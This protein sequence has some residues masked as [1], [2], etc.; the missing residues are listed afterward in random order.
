MDRTLPLPALLLALLLWPAS[1]FAAPANES[2][3]CPS[4]APTDPLQRANLLSYLCYLAIPQGDANW[5]AEYPELLSSA[6]N[7]H[8]AA[9][10]ELAFT[11]TDATYW[12]R[13]NVHNPSDRAGFWYLKLNYAPLDYVTLMIDSGEG[14]QRIETGDQ[15]PFDS[16]GIDYR[17]YLLPIALEEGEAKRI[18]IKLRSSGALN[19]PLSLITT[20]ELVSYSN[21]LTLTHGLFYGAISIFAIFNLLLF[22]SSRT[23][24][25]FYNAFYMIAM[26]LFLFAMGGFAYQHLW[27]GMPLM[28]NTAIPLLIALCALSMNLF[29][30]SFLEV[31][32]NRSATSRLLS[33]QSAIS[34]LLLLLVF[35]L[36]YTTAIKINTLFALIVICNLFVIGVL[37]W[38]SGYA[39]A[40]WYVLSWSLMVLGTSSYALAAFGFLPDFLSHEMTMQAAIGGQIVL[41]NY[42]MVQRWRLLNNQLLAVE[43]DAKLRLEQQVQQRTAQL[44]AAMADL[45]LANQRLE[46]LTTQDGLTGLNNRRFLDAM[47]SQL[48]AESRRTGKPLSLV[49]LDA[50]HFKQVNDRYGH[51]FGDRC[52]AAIAEVLA[53]N[54]HRPQDVVARFGGEEF[55]LLLPDTDESGAHR[56]CRKILDDMSR[57]A[58]VGEEGQRVRLTLSA[59]IATSTPG[60]TERHLF[61]RADQALYR[62]KALGR[63]RTETALAVTA[64]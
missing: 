48:L 58:M 13:L 8:S 4:V 39:H 36:N 49:L 60:E 42:A 10:Q 56:V 52:L 44:R 24:Y 33:A 54:I 62:A 57:V 41:L 51:A 7:W 50:D 6:H 12:I 18:T 25:Y 22:V 40:K 45:E 34:L 64:D 14:H 37:R 43:H 38:R 61:E 53:R 35:E 23:T 9:G 5:Q 1:L 20:D 32:Q 30:R 15:R 27:P 63:N 17:Y 31:K 55:A 26:G 16:R 47:F 59:G 11:Q 28:A 2:S 3:Q 21:N 29:G 46:E 19:V